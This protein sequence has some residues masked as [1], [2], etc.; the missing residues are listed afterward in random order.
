MLRRQERA[1]TNAGAA[2]SSVRSR[3]SVSEG[4]NRVGELAF[5]RTAEV[6]AQRREVA[7]LQIDD[8]S[9]LDA[10]S[11][12]AVLNRG[13]PAAA[14]AELTVNAAFAYRGEDG[15]LLH[16]LPR[17][18]IGPIHRAERPQDRAVYDLAVHGCQVLEAYVDANAALADE[19]GTLL[20]EDMRGHRTR[21][22]AARPCSVPQTFLSESASGSYAE[23]DGDGE[24]SCT[25]HNSS[26]L[27]TR[28]ARAGST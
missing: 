27:T 22:R 14:V 7:Q 6:A 5:L 26:L 12:Q 24:A 21:G 28:A 4:R 17:L 23:R 18:R 13:S 2:P 8:D 16:R 25:N 19:A 15:N 1:V 3:G 9:V 11:V 10:L 20:V